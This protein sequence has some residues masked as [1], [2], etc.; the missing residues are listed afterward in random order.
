[1]IIEKDEK[2][3]EEQVFELGCQVSMLEELVIQLIGELKSNG[4][5]VSD[6]IRIEKQEDIE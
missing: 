1:M 6:T 2:T 3:L 4:I 5:Q